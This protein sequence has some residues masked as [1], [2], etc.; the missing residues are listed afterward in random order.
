MHQGTIVFF[1]PE[2]GY[3]YLRLL[4]THEEFYFRAEQLTAGPVRA[5]DPVTFRLAYRKRTFVAEA[6]TPSTLA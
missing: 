4:G 2:R 6:V 3:G 5:G 1:L